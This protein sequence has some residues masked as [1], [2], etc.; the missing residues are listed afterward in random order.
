WR[1]G[2]Q[3]GSGNVRAVRV[4]TDG[5]ILDNPPITVGV[6][7][8]DRTEVSIAAVGDTWLVA[9]QSATNVVASRVS[10]TGAVLDSPPLILSGTASQT[11]VPT[12]ASDGAQFKVSWFAYVDPSTTN[13]TTNRV[14]P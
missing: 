7:Y 12:V 6:E 13:L 4:A 9:W 1:E 3:F 5:G 10:P 2:Q 11:A 14:T 8:A